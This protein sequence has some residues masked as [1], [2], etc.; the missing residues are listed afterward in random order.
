M[1]VDQL[2]VQLLHQER[3]RVRRQMRQQPIE[4]VGTPGLPLRLAQ[5]RLLGLGERG[6][7]GV[8]AAPIVT[9]AGHGFHTCASITA[10]SGYPG[11]VR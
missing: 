9:G 8:H 6:A 3:R 11:A 5:Q 2:A 4:L 10:G 1:Y 7:A